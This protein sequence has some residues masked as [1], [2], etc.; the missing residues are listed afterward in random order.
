[1][2]SPAVDVL[3]AVRAPAP[4]LAETLSSLQ[5]QDFG[6]HRL[7]AVMDGFDTGI[8]ALL[9]GWRGTKLVITQP[10]SSGLASCLNAGLREAKAPLVARI[11]AD[12]LMR[13]DR[14]DHQVRHMTAHPKCLAVS[15]SMVEIDEAGTALR[16]RRK[17]ATSV[18]NVLGRLRWRSAL[19]HPATMYRTGV[20]RDLGGYNEEAEGVE[21]YEL[22]LRLAAIGELHRLREPLTSYR[23][24]QNQ[25]SVVSKPSGRAY[26]A[27]R[28]ARLSL[29]Q[30]RYESVI[31]AHAR[32]LVW[33]TWQAIR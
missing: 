22:W 11:D 4:W 13:G 3:M 25:V 18:Q 2:T 32:H 21:D 8:D 33:R 20:V 19:S 9:R 17:Q 16:I 28:H 5:Y 23:I 1:M 29:A 26:A 12:D 7:I 15:S 27:V 24:H 30:N 6:D 10:K 31:A 14:L